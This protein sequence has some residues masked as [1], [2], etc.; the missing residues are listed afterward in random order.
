[1]GKWARYFQKYPVYGSLVG[2]RLLVLA[3]FIVPILLGAAMAWKFGGF[4]NARHKNGGHEMS[5]E[6]YK[7]WKDASTVMIGL[8]FTYPF[9]PY[10]IP[11]GVT[12]P[13]IAV[14]YLTVVHLR[15]W[16]A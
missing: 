6:R 11:F 4:L 10:P 14:W 13:F 16:R 12:L 1:M 15:K 7:W 8:F 5:Q 2:G 3:G 9:W